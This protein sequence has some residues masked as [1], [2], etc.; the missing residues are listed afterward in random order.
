MNKN[1][2]VPNGA[3]AEPKEVLHDIEGEG[4]TTVVPNKEL[5]GGEPT[6]GSLEVDGRNFKV[7]QVDE[8]K[9]G[10]GSD[11][12]LFGE[13]I[14]VYSSGESPEL[15]YVLFA[16]QGLTGKEVLSV[17]VDL[18]PYEDEPENVIH[19]KCYPLFKMEM[20]GYSNQMFASTYAGDAE[21]VAEA[22]EFVS[23]TY[24]EI[25]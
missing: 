10:L 17:N 7:P 13:P 9:T 14:P 15:L 12:T 18:K 8:I 2:M 19:E 21:V 25:N 24:R 22:F 1:L 5:V 3:N 23:Y 16:I 4:G 20:N 6:L 11:L